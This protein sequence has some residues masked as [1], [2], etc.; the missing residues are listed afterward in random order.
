MVTVVCGAIGQNSFSA[1]ERDLKKPCATILFRIARLYG[2]GIE[3]LLTA[4]LTAFPRTKPAAALWLPRA[5][6]TCPRRSS[7][8]CLWLT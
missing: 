2:K 8:G 5:A 4:R 3:R 1:P 7:G 6:P